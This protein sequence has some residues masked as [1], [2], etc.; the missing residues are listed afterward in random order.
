MNKSHADSS[1][2]KAVTQVIHH[3]K[4]WRGQ[5]LK[6]KQPKAKAVFYWGFILNLVN[7][8]SYSA[9]ANPI[10]SDYSLPT[11]SQLT[12]SSNIC[13]I[14]QGTLSG[15]NLFHSFREFSL[16]KGG[17]AYFNN[18]QTVQNI[19]SR[20]TGTSISNIDGLIKANGNANLF[21]VNPNGITFGSDAK[22]DI[23]G[24]FLAT[25]ASAIKFADGSLFSA[26][27]SPTQPLLT[28]SVPVGLQFGARPGNILVQG[29]GTGFRTTTDLID[30]NDALRVQPNQTLALVGGDITLAGGTLKTAGGRIELGSVGDNSF[31][32]INQ[33]NSGT[34]LGYDGVSAFKDIIL[35]NQAAVDASGLGAGNIQIVGRRVALRNASQIQASTLGSQPGGKITVQGTDAVELSGT[36]ADGYFS[37]SLSSDVYQEATG[38]A[39]DIRI[40]TRHLTIRDGGYISSTTVG[41]GSLGT[42]AISASDL[43]EVIGTTPDGFYPSGIFSYLYEAGQGASGFLTLETQGLIVRDGGQIYTSTFGQGSAG[44]LTVN[45]LDFVE[46]SGTNS[47]GTFSS[48]LFTSVEPSATGNG[49]QLSLQTRRLS[50]KQGAFISA[51]TTG[52]GAGGSV[53]IN[54][55][56]LIEVMGKSAIG[57]IPSR[58]SARA[59]TT[60]TQA[61]GDL[62]I[63]TRQFIV[64]DEAEVTVSSKNSA[65]AGNLEITARELFLNNQGKLIAE[66]ASGNGG[67]MKIE[68][69]NLILLRGNSLISTTAGSV[70]NGGNITIDSQFIVAMPSENSDIIA[71]AFK[72]RG[73]YI[74]IAAKSIF[75]LQSRPQQ[76]TASDIT[77]SSELG[78]SGT[79][80]INTPGV[81][82]SKGLIDLPTNLTAVNSMVSQ[83][84][85]VANSSNDNQFVITGKGGLAANP[86]EL[87]N[88]ETVLADLGSPAAQNN[89]VRVNTFPTSTSARHQSLV[90]A[91]GWA[92]N[93]AGQVMLTASSSQ[94]TPSQMWQ[95]PAQCPAAEK[96]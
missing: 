45:A 2:F 42:L 26:A 86:N 82:P 12:C 58:L 19:I 59:A 9:N 87:I 63:N 34:D 43:I 66:T 64:G 93:Q 36:S 29:Q 11:P 16:A 92:I 76:T 8:F 75:G 96:L 13:Q 7:F 54:A 39:S 80:N 14:N 73:G 94:V 89:Q 70:G 60:A 69:A 22:L 68:G 71:N 84:C 35:D 85:Q 77:A 3:E 55:T 17:E 67:N 41:K 51:G 65:S 33:I 49:G 6:W 52:N 40:Q 56:E 18:N 4:I 57:N 44:K 10:I 79:V 78:V 90:E 50:V 72:G 46:L 88:G 27:T 25:T 47:L 15:N 62:K 20:V 23:G 24:S 91:Q 21:L 37:S 38:T 31:V 61:A 53:E 1:S 81:D 5:N 74:N 95:N 83:N 30:T 28:I 48:G 32:S